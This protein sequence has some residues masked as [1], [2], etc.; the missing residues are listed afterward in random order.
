MEEVKGD[1]GGLESQGDRIAPDCN[2]G[3]DDCCGDDSD[4]DYYDDDDDE[5]DNYVYEDDDAYQVS[6]GGAVGQLESKTIIDMI[7]IIETIIIIMR[8]DVIRTWLY[9]EAAVKDLQPAS[10]EVISSDIIVRGLR[11]I[12]SLFFSS[13]IIDH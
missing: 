4:S 2:D 10:L 8:L 13:L 3:D 11:I 9:R 1:G 6:Q 5:S 12:K 7:I